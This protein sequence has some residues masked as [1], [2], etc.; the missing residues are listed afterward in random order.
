MPT[1]TGFIS[2]LEHSGSDAGFFATVSVDAAGTW[3]AGDSPTWGGRMPDPWRPR[4]VPRGTPVPIRSTPVTMPRPRWWSPLR[5]AS[6]T[7]ADATEAGREARWPPGFP[8]RP[9][10]RGTRPDPPMFCL[11]SARGRRAPL[12]PRTF[13]PFLPRS[14]APIRRPHRVCARGSRP[15]WTMPGFAGGQAVAVRPAGADTLNISC[16]IRAIWRRASIIAPS[17]GGRRPSHD[18]RFARRTVWTRGAWNCSG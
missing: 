5:L 8:A 17:H 14:G 16:R 6:P 2:R 12:R 10:T 3:A 4:C 1:A 15:C 7:V 11:P 13:W 9:R 18:R